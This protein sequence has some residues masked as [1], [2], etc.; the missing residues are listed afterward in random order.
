MSEI[1][2]IVSK[3]N[4]EYTIETLKTII[5]SSFKSPYE[6][7]VGLG[8]EGTEQE[9][10]NSLKGDPGTNGT[11]GTNGKS[12]YDLA[13]DEGY[14]GTLS[15]WLDSLKGKSFEMYEASDR[16]DALTYSANHP[17]VLVYVTKEE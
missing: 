17:N 11:N 10:L 15:E 3:D 6:L 8:F 4:L 9:W 5:K 1:K 14:E 13:V 16:E 7:A 2:K 12:A